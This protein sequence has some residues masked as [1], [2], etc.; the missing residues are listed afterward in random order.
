M[1]NK[2]HLQ[3]TIFCTVITSGIVVLLTVICLFLAEDSLRKNDSA[4]F[5]RQ[6][7][8]VLL[9]LQEQDTVSHQWLNQIQKKGQ[10]MLYIYDNNKPLYYQ[11]YHDSQEETLK[12]EVIDRARDRYQMDIFRCENKQVIAH[13]EFDF[14][15][16]AGEDYYVSAGTIPKGKS[17]LSFLLL[18]P[19]EK[20]KAEVQRLRLLICLADLAAMVLLFL[21]AWFFTGHILLPLENSRKKQIHFIASASHELRAPLSVIQSGLEVLQKTDSAEKRQH[22]L[23]YMEEESSRMKNLIQDLLLLAK[24]DSGSQS[25]H[26]EMCQPEEL[27]IA[28][29]E[30]YEPIARKKQ[31]RLSILLPEEWINDCSCDREKITQLLSILLDNAISYTP[32]GGKVALSL[33]QGKSVICFSVADTGQ[34]IQEEEKGRIF[35]RF[36][37]SDQAHSDKSHFGLGLCIA[38]EIVQGHQGKIWVED[39]EGGGS[40]FLVEL[41]EDPNNGI[42]HYRDSMLR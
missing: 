10:I 12:T 16:S 4:S 39:V 33:R 19:L 6:L 30:K 22:C 31:I 25:F 13:A 1:F 18:Y 37:R 23:K 15:S 28:A 24:A 3:F 34:G 32:D 5:L 11:N 7:N 17:Y 36:Y 2:L 21:F 20:Q 9:P 14:S 26:M 38:R 41:P 8:S 42:L 29:Y 40:C 27:L 35:D